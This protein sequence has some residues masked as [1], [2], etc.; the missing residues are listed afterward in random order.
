LPLTRAATA[1]QLDLVQKT[2]AIPRLSSP[3]RTVRL[4]S[5]VPLKRMR[6]YME[7]RRMTGSNRSL[8]RRVLIVLGATL[9]LMGARAKAEPV[10]TAANVPFQAGTVMQTVSA[11]LIFWLP[12]YPNGVLL[13]PTVPGGF[14]NFSAS[15]SSSFAT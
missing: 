8:T 6:R 11:F 4:V 12:G 7:G 10:P 5:P 14:G 2:L 3:C 9:A 15:P 13:D 1:A